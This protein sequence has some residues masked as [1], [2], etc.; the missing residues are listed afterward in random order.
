MEY[1]AGVPA[2]D[3]LRLHGFSTS[4]HVTT[5]LLLFLIKF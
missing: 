1:Q 5:M 3:L 2:L 4:S